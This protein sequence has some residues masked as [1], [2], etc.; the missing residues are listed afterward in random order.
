VP[1]FVVLGDRSGIRFTTIIHP[2]P[3]GLGLDTL[4]LPGGPDGLGHLGQSVLR[5]VP[6]I[7]VTPGVFE[8]LIP[9]MPARLS[10]D[11]A[12]AGDSGLQRVVIATAFNPPSEST[13]GELVT[14]DA[15]GVAAGAALRSG[16]EGGARRIGIPL[17]GAGA[18]DLDPGAV[19]DALVPNVLVAASELVSST[20]HEVVFLTH[21]P[22]ERDAVERAWRGFE[23]PAFSNDRPTGPDL[24]GVRAEVYALADMLLLRE[25]E[26]PLAVGVLGGW[27]SGKSFV[28][29]LLEERMR[30]IRS[31]VLEETEAW[32]GPN[33]SPFVGH[34][35]LIRFNAWTYARGD[36][37]AALIYTVLSEL[38]HQLGLERRLRDK[39][40]LLDGER[41]K[42]LWE[43]PGALLR[44]YEE[45]DFP[46]EAG[47]QVSRVLADVHQSNQQAVA[48][49][50]RTVDHLRAEEAKREEEVVRQAEA[51]VPLSLDRAKWMAMLRRVAIRAGVG[52][53]EVSDLVDE[54]VPKLVR[55]VDDANASVSDARA[56]MSAALPKLPR[57][58][59]ALRRYYV[60]AIAIL[61]LGSAV[62]AGL[63]QADA[64]PTGAQV[65]AWIVS[66]TA[67]VGSL[68]RVVQAG[69]RKLGQV[70]SV[71]RELSAMLDHE[72]GSDEQRQ[73][74]IES[75]KAKD[76]TLTDLRKDRRRSEATLKELEEK[77]A[78]VDKF[79]SIN[80]LVKTRLQAGGYQAQLG[81]MQQISE[82]LRDLT[83]ALVVA[84]V[85][86]Y[87]TDKHEAFPRGPARIV[88]F[89]DDLDRCPPDKVVA[90]LEAVQLLLATDLFIVVVSID[91]QYVTK[92]LEKEYENVLKADGD[93]SGID[94]L[95]KIIQIPYRTR[96][97]D[98]D[99]AE[100]FLRG[101]LRVVAPADPLATGSG[102]PRATDATEDVTVNVELQPSSAAIARQLEFR[103]E[104]VKVIAACCARVGLSPRATKRVG[105]VVKLFRLVWARRG[106]PAPALEET[107]AVA[108]LLALAAVHPEAQRRALDHLRDV[109]RGDDK[110]KTVL[111][112]LGDVRDNRVSSAVVP[113]DMGVG[114]AMHRRWS[115]AL[116]AVTGSPV[117]GVPGRPVPGVPGDQPFVIGE[118]NLRAAGRAV[119]FVSAF[120]FVGDQAGPSSPRVSVL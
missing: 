107:A 99:A 116:D 30:E 80:D 73:R 102:T 37:W 2:E 108:L 96:V 97:P 34:V 98:V 14:P 95:E 33:V 41:W 59:A 48:D 94:Y 110:K 78:L 117:P 68:T 20:L 72:I 3:W 45:T 35:Y 32:T 15:A 25:V 19:A 21:R 82:D 1:Q 87:E 66:V 53:A 50:R 51:E 111:E 109:L 58:G 89:I 47:L 23:T 101:H 92:A 4:V 90:V 104:E 70:T 69:R 67:L 57:P 24:L 36:L 12:Q 13:A 64:W 43:V 62:M 120:C 76:Q 26:A 55:A 31:S 44:L 61:A 86:A 83:N 52:E 18:A 54:A 40:D 42:A 7:T 115:K 118:T 28:M 85:D 106:R 112:A 114:E 38:D 119:D 60:G 74:A 6:G 8:Y 17:I 65:T 88:L 22:E 5:A 113:D 79:T 27:G 46:G 29:G 75:R 77:A 105:N 9:E 16:V 56:A 81:M 93:P 39:G 84:P 10:V 91:V 49:E 11:P 100:R 103:L 63:W 71:V